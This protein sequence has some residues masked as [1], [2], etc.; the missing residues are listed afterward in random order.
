MRV[1]AYGTLRKG[2]G[3]HYIVEPF[4][5]SIQPGTIRGTMYHAGYFPY[6]IQRGEGRV[7]GEWLS[8][9]PDKE[10]EALSRMD[11]MEGY[12]GEGEWNH[13]ERIWVRDE[14]NA[15]LEGWVYVAGRHIEPERRYPVVE[16]GDWSRRA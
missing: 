6:V 4:V 5:E 8:I 15:A 9:R 14:V 1:F 11:I 16:S 7:I 3:N 13:Y 10:E 12:Y 2:F